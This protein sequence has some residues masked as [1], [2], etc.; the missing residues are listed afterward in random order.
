MLCDHE[1]H[2]ASGVN[3]NNVS[4]LMNTLVVASVVSGQQKHIHAHTNGQPWL[5]IRTRHPLQVHITK[6]Y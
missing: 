3:N 6:L 4:A 2:C 1:C 5:F